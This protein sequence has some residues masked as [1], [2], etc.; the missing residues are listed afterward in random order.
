MSSSAW[1]DWPRRARRAAR[2]YGREGKP[3][4]LV[5]DVRVDMPIGDVRLLVHAWTLRQFPTAEHSAEEIAMMDDF[6]I[7]LVA[8]W[9]KGA[10]KRRGGR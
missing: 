5:S 9:Q 3:F 7:Y 2:N 6:L 10:R 8:A 1:N 4:P